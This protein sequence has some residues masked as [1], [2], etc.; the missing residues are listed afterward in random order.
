MPRTPGALRPWLV[1]TLAGLALAGLAGCRGGTY[2]VSGR[3]EYDDGEPI[4]GALTGCTITFTSE[5][6]GVEA[7]GEIQDD[8]SFRLGTRGANDGAPPGTYKVIVAQPHPAPERPEKRRPVVDLAYEDPDKTP[9]EATVE[10]KSNE[11]TFKLNRL[12]GKK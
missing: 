3:L 11:F 9:L 4:Q 6:L 2:P 8:G 12:K 5:K 1:I 7:R 10:P